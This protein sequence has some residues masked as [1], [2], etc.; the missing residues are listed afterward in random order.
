MHPKHN[1]FATFD[2]WFTTPDTSPRYD[3]MSGAHNRE[4]ETLP[5]GCAM[6]MIPN[7]GDTLSMAATVWVSCFGECVRYWPGARF[8]NVPVRFRA[9]NEIFKL[10]S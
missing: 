6:L 9:R 2:V 8:S 5:D 4:R 7:K 1:T 10:K 3:E